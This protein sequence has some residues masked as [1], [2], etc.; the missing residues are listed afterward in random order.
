MFNRLGIHWKGLAA[1]LAAGC[2]ALPLTAR[3]QASS[4][5]PSVVPSPKGDGSTMTLMRR[6]TQADRAGAALRALQRKKA[7]AAVAPAAAPKLA[8]K[9]APKAGASRLRAAGTASRAATLAPALPPYDLYA[10][11]NYATSKYPTA[12]CSNSPGVTCQKDADCPGYQPPF[13]IGPNLFPSAETCTGP[14]VPGTG[15]QKFVDTLPGFCSVTGPNDLGNC[16]PIAM[17]DTS[18]FP[19]ADYYEIGLQDYRYQFHRDLPNKTKVRGYY[20]KNTSDPYASKNFYLGPFIVARTD[21]PVRVKFTNELGVG[22]AGDFFIPV[23]KTLSGTDLGPDGTPYTQNRATVHLHGGNSPWI[24]DGT[25]HQWTTPVGENTTTHKRGVNVEFVPDMWFDVN[26]NPLAAC[27]GQVSCAVPGATNDPGDGR[28]TFYW[29]NQQSGRLMF[30]HDHAYGITR[31][32]VYAGEAA[33]YLLVKP[34]DEDRLAAATVPGTLGTKFFDPASAVTTA[35]SPDLDHVIPL[36]LQDKTFVPPAAQLAQQDPTWDPALWSGEDGLWYPHVYTP[37]QWPGNPDL[38][39][40]NPMGRW[41][42]GPWFWPMQ[43]SLTGVTW[44][45]QVVNRPLTIP[46]RSALAVDPLTN[47]NGDTECPSTPSPSMVPES[48]LDTPVV[49]GTAYP[50]LTVDPAAYRFQILN[51][52]NERNFNLSLFVADASGTE[53]KMVDA[54]PHSSSSVPPL[55]SGSAPLSDVTGSPNGPDLGPATCWPRDWPVDARQ[56]GVPD[57]ATVGPKWIQIGSEAG[58]LPAPAVIPPL[59]VNYELNKRNIVVLNVSTKALF[60]GPAERA[61]VVVDFSAYAGKTLIL[62]NDSPAPVPAGD[63]RQ[64]LYTGAPDQTT[65]GGAPSP[66][67][68]YG[69]NNRTVMQI[70]VRAAASASQPP[71]DLAAITTALNQAFAG[72]QPPPIVPEAVYNQVYNPATPFANTYL[73]IQALSLTFT[74]IGQSQPVT[75]P[76]ANKALHELFTTDQGRMNSLLGVEIPNTNWLNQTTIPFANFDPTT[77]FLTDGVPQIW[78]ITHNGVDT[79][80]IHFH[81]FNA[82]VL[83]RVGWDGQI[84]APDANELGWKEVVRMN[85]LEDVLIALKPVKQNLPWPLPDKI[86]PLDVDRPLGTASQFTGVDVNNNPIQ[87][88]NQLVNFGQEYIWHCHLLGHEEEDMM[89]SE[90]LVTAPEVPS[91]LVV[92]QPLPTDQPVLVWRDESKSAMT[93]TVQRSTDPTFANDLVT[94]S[95]AAPTVQPGPAS[96]TDANALVGGQVY[97]YRVRGEKVLTSPA[98]PGQT[99]PATSNWS[100][101]AQLGTVALVTVSPDAVA[102]GDQRVGTAS[103]ARSVTLTAGGITSL[104]I[105]VV[106]AQAADFAIASTS[107]C[108]PSL[109]AGASCTV[110]LVFKPA[111]LGARAATL[112]ILTSASVVPLSVALTGNGVAP[113]ASVSPLT[114]SFGNQLVNVTSAAQA[115]TLTNTGTLPLTVTGL[116]LAGTNPGDFAQTSTCPVAPAT[117][118]AGA[119]CTVSVTFRP[120]ALAAR[121]ARLT[122]S[123]DDPITPVVTVT[124]DGTGIAPLLTVNPNALAFVNQLVTNPPA[125]GA[126][127]TVTLTN[128]GTAPVASLA[129]GLSGGNAAEF[130][131]VSSS[132]GTTLAAGGSCTVAVAFAPATSGAKA[133]SLVITGTDGVNPIPA[134]AVALTGTDVAPVAGLAPNPLTFAAQ[135]LNTPSAPQT[136]TLSNT[137]TAP[138]TVSGITASG[139]FSQTSS[140]A[141]VAAGASCAIT[142]TFTPTATGTRSG[143]VTVTSSDPVNPTLTAAVN[144]MGTAISLSPSVLAFGTQL[145]GTTSASRSVTLINTGTTALAI[146]SVGVSGANAADYAVTNNCAASLSAGRSCTLGVRFTPAA[147]GPS[148]AT[149]SVVTSDP[150]GPATVALSGT[151]G[152]PVAAVAPTSLAFTSAMNVTSAA[153][154]VTVTNTGTSPL[155]LNGTALGGTDPSQFA[156]TSTCGPSLAAGA[157]CTI[158]VTFTPTTYGGVLTKSA[159]LTVNVAAPATSQTVSLTGTILVPTYTLTPTALTFAKQTVGTTSAAQTVTLANTGTAPLGIRGITLGGNNPGSFAQTNSCGTSVAAGASCTISVTFTPTRVGSRT[160]TL[161]VRVSAP[162]VSQSVTLTGSGQ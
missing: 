58:L 144:G 88:T 150:A 140:C 153:Q 131:V 75:I 25:Q 11:P 109:G 82:Q 49:N 8:P 62:Y 95:A 60:M 30:F 16:L 128:G 104:A 132:C 161:N 35:T 107:T 87:I 101:V 66:L 116:A 50:T 138:L 56:G 18:T 74:P 103:A 72:S 23:D 151:G 53:V 123:T 9:A 15:I 130:Q 1:L 158:D 99:F 106:G 105:S 143:T 70:K 124:L 10:S 89:R 127:Q 14:V 55:C 31:L 77:E 156:R 133:A 162:A 76:F 34:D 113:V 126:A 61:D 86:R 59:P 117:L 114:L 24:S 22:A 125:A 142:V 134:Q 115:V 3:A 141:T 2:V 39:S 21:R 155:T 112:E 43:T 91:S 100:N 28:L 73:P 19:G 108:G 20:Q 47:P 90:V 36:V 68:G 51:A 110:D 135:T 71:V 69:P 81:L 97:Y 44:D 96:A 139:D 98:L 48:F 129:A 12:T 5:Q 6:T 121:G 119:A 149:L 80:T 17:P 33:G 54:V 27:S 26:G 118:A 159:T 79:H 41:D 38:S 64:D 32:G 93:F 4:A 52:A 84:R 42:Y 102:F 154:T 85:P 67:P 63:P 83:N 45:G 111:A 137:G 65:V 40:T 94:F 122:V 78:K 120:S 145:V 136:L 13:L 29:T 157:S 146:T 148:T 57:P 37:N 147:V 152:V 160:A 46:C 92:S 7:N